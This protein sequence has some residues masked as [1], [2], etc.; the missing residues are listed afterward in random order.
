[1][2]RQALPEPNLAM[3]DTSSE[4]LYN[5]DRENTRQASPAADEARPAAVGKLFSE[6]M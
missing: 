2:L 1:M 3:S 5:F 6:Q 4:I